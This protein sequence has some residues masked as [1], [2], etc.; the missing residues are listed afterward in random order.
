MW[1]FPICTRTFSPFF[2]IQG[3]VFQWRKSTSHFFKALRHQEIIVLTFWWTFVSTLHWGVLSRIVMLSIYVF[4]T[5][6]WLLCGEWVGEGIQGHQTIQFFPF[7]SELPQ[8]WNSSVFSKF[9]FFSDLKDLFTYL[10]L[11]IYL[12]I[13][14]WVH[15]ELF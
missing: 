12:Y 15:R 2:S 4:K 6:F 1:S 13:H 14:T 8:K 7:G 9:K 5:L 10:C 3:P 11:S